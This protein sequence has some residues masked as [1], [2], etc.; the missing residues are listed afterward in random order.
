MLGYSQTRNEVFTLPEKIPQKICPK[1]EL[2]TKLLRL[3]AMTSQQWGRLK[4]FQGKFTAVYLRF[5]YGGPD[6]HVLL[7][8]IEGKLVHVQ[9]IVPAYKLK[10]RYRFVPD[11]SHSIIS[12]LTRHDLRGLGIF[13]SQIQRVVESDIPAKLFWIWSAST[14]APSLKGIRKAGGIKVGEFVHKKWFWGCVSHIKYFPKGT[15]GR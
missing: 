7:A 2:N 6:T 8:F 1:V 5:R 12:C 11:N 15:D 4:Q 13:P 3:R 9:W 14:N 10:R